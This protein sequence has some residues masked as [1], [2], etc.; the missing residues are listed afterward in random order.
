MTEFP[1]VTLLITHYNRSQSL[2]RLLKTM[3]Q[4]QVAF[5]GIVVSDDASK[6]EHQKRLEELKAEYGYR[7]VTTPVNRGLGHNLNKGQD[8]VTT[9]YTLYAQEDFTPTAKFPAA[10]PHALEILKE[11]PD[12]DVVRMHAYSHYPY[13]RPYKNGFDEMVFKLTKPGSAKFFYYSD[14]PHLRRSSFFAK[15]GRYAEGIK[16][17]KT[18]KCMVMSFLQAGGKG[19][20]YADNDLFVHE[21][22]LEPST[23]DYSAFFRIKQKIPESVFDVVWTARLTAQYLVKPYRH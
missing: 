10:F 19:M 20:I 9:P 12:I 21:N 15:F 1:E 14:H 18:E 7:L 8:A 22:T 3:R 4:M 17:I 11:R 13:T 2:E 5:G 23:Q 16:A 6:P